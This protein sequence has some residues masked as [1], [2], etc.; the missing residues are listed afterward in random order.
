MGISVVAL[1]I[2]YGMMEVQGIRADKKMDKSIT[3]LT[4][5][6]SS[7]KANIGGEWELIDTNGKKFGSKDLEGTYYL[8][9]FG[10]CNCPD[11]CPNSLIKLSKALAKIRKM[12]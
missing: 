7:G 6:T 5:V 12:P 3:G 11:I 9:Y 4:K 10:F 2:A 1:L 8:I